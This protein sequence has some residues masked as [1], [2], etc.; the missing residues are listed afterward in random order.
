M[1]GTIPASTRKSRAVTTCFGSVFGPVTIPTLRPSTGHFSPIW[2][3]A[4][5][6]ATSSAGGVFGLPGLSPRPE[7]TRWA[8]SA[9][10]A[11]STSTSRA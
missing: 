7:A 6:A 8:S 4:G 9:S 10:T 11:A 5:L 2:E 3:S 1:I